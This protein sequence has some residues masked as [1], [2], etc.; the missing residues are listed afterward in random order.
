M[1]VAYFPK[2]VSS[3]KTTLLLGGFESFH[4]GHQ[5]LL[6]KAK[7]FKKPIS[8][9]LIENPATMPGHNKKVFQSLDVRLQ[10]IANYG[11]DY[12]SVVS[13]DDK[14]Q[15]MSGKDFLDQLIKSTNA[16]NIIMGKDF[17]LGKGRELEALD[18]AKQYENV[19]IIET[20]KVNNKKIS[21]SFLKELVV[22]GEVDLI[23]K[24]AG[25]PLTVNVKVDHKGLVNWGENI[26]PHTGIYGIYVIQN[27]VQYFGL[28]H[29]SM[30]KKIN[31]VVPDLNVVNN[32]YKPTILLKKKV[33]T[34]IKDTMD[35][36]LPTDLELVIE[37]LN[38]I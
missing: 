36:V 27:D 7:E 23:E 34:I 17:A 26:I 3:T 2:K 21:S 5:R 18:I 33:R 6:N 4:L 24:L 37:A 1:K 20:Y 25:N 12:V 30:E 19:S 11:I 14:I 10:Q 22:L 8:I 35:K 16:T 29:V 15:T 31:I 32:S 9:M 13:F 28:L 38:T